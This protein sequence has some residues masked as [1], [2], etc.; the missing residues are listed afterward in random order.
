VHD[1][2]A[3]V[4]ALTWRGHG[5]YRGRQEVLGLPET[6]PEEGLEW[7]RRQLAGLT[8]G[9]TLAMAEARGLRV[10]G[11]PVEAKRA[12][13]MQGAQEAEVRE[14]IA[15]FQRLRKEVDELVA[16]LYESDGRSLG[17]L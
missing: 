5:L 2:N 13:E 15:E 7:L 10:P 4:T 11:S 14:K 8:A 16:A 17:I 9:T 3:D 12:L 6:A 1:D